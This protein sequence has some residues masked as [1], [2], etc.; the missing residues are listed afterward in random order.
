MRKL[1]RSKKDQL[2]CWKWIEKSVP[3]DH[4]LSSLSK[5]QKLGMKY[6]QAKPV[7]RMTSGSCYDH[8]QAH[9]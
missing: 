1:I 8:E 7:L 9:I 6:V 3:T 5:P 2:F 4:Y